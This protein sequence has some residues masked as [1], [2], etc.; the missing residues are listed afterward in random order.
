MRPQQKQ[1]YISQTH[2]VAA[3][4]EAHEQGRNDTVR[5]LTEE[6]EPMQQR[7]KRHYVEQLLDTSQIRK[8]NG[9]KLQE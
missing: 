8:R 2:M 5:E 6:N 4:R 1:K 7:Q 3:S 9:S